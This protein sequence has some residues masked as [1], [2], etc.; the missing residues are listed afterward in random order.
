MLSRRNRGAHHA[1]GFHK[2]QNSS[3]TRYREPS[4]TKT[5]GRL[6]SCRLIP[7]FFAVAVLF[8]LLSFLAGSYLL[9]V[10]D[11]LSTLLESSVSVFTGPQR[12]TDRA[13]VGYRGIYHIE[14]GDIGGAAGTVFFQF[15]IGQILWAEMYNFK[16]WVHLNNVSYIV[17]DP[18]VHGQGPGVQFTMQEGPNITYIHRPDGH[19]KDYVPGPPKH[20]DVLVQKNYNF[21][22]NGVWNNYFEPVS[23]F[24]PGDTSCR[25]KPLVTMDLYQVTPGVHGFA[26]WAPR[27][28]RYEYLPDY[29]TRPHI[30]LQEWLEPQRSIGHRVLNQYIRF[31]P[32]IRRKAENFNPSCSLSSNSCLG[33]HIRQSDK[34]AGRR[35]IQTDEFLPYVLAFVESGG[36]SIYL[37]TDSTAVV[38]H[39]KTK[40]PADIQK[41]IRSMGDDIIR[42]TSTEAVFDIGS[43]H[44][45]NTEIFIEI[46]AL[47]KCQF[48]IHGLSAVTETSIWINL[49][50]HA[51][52]VNLEDPDH[53]DVAA[54]KEMVSKVLSGGNATEIMLKRRTSN[55]WKND[56]TQVWRRQ[57]THAACEGSAGILH[58]AHVG[59]RAGAGTAFFT[60]VVN[61]LIYAEDNNLTPWIHLGEEAEY[62][63]EDGVHGVGEPFSFQAKVDHDISTIRHT[64]NESYEYPGPLISSGR[65]QTNTLS[66]GGTGIWNSYF[67]PVSDFHKDDASCHNQPLLSMEYSMVTSP[68]NSWSPWSVKAW[69][70]D[71]IP[72]RLWKDENVKLKDFLAPMRLR[73]SEIVKKH[74]RF[75]SFIEAKAQ[76][77]NPVDASSPCLAVHLRNSDKGAEK[78]R[79]KFPPNKF[80]AYMQAFINA[81]GKHIFIASDS[82]RTLEYIR[83]HFPSEMNN[84][85]RTQGQYV[86]R[87]TKKWPI[88]SLEK[89]HRTNSEALV[90]ILAMSKCSMLLHGHSA[91][92]EAAIYL[93]PDLHNTSVNWEDPDKMSVQEFEDMS[94]TLLKE[95]ALQLTTETAMVE[96]HIKHPTILHG[97][98]SRTCRK[99]AIVYLA[100][101]KHSSYKGRDSY[102]LLLESLSLIHKNYL[103]LNDHADNVDIIIFH[104]ADFDAADLDVFRSRFG[105]GFREMVHFV[106]LAN[107]TYWKR[108]KWHESDS[109]NDWY[110]FPLFSEGYRRMMHFFAVD[111]WNFFRD[112]EESSG[113]SYRYIMRFD[114]DSYLHSPIQYNIFDF[115]EKNKY[116]YGF[117]LCA[118]E[119]QV[120]QR[121]W[122]LWRRRKNN[123]KPI[124]DIEL[125]MCGIYNNFFVANLA[126][127]QS[128]PVQKF[129]NFV[130]RQGFI[131]RRRLG[132]LMIHSM[133][134]YAFTPPEQIHRFLDFTYEHG[135]VNHTSGCVV[136]GG[137]QAGYDDPHADETLNSFWQRKVADVGNC[138][139]KD[140]LLSKENL[141]PTY[142]HLPPE[143]AG[144]QL[145]TIMD[146]KI[147]LPDKGALS[148]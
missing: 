42:S 59:H 134:T 75:H 109:P 17:Y 111:I 70:Y 94:R 28:W 122:R 145:R 19:M 21:S 77:V 89:H 48:M 97:S 147:E 99:N 16:P 34:A 104:T 118:Y 137:I 62:I 43:H 142:S 108:P 51:T 74:F 10:E 85:I 27:C 44:R 146:G 47:S 38:D 31:L 129:L 114:E 102:G 119:M 78:H 126:H 117:R 106:D 128:Q 49:D 46:L 139:N 87:S 61:Q 36:S 69:R 82:H 76:E 101:K 32:H 136:W 138:A 57:P 92:S 4:P 91:V 68:L 26:E 11:S 41:R 71:D 55:W 115:M 58:I 107:T 88:H 40:W 15:V 98:E 56:D 30:P 148:G 64:F 144:V 12:P 35:Q 84:A 39:I 105:E 18:K 141:S 9:S 22:G 2:Q 5:R 20:M 3:S 81:G 45:T 6:T 116:L 127:F 143:K 63:Y 13:C 83:E 8:M 100:Q 53:S 135:T 95:S 133:A 65:A 124:R 29:I 93:N 14:K 120:T 131:Y 33:I 132:D 96:G 54:F 130:D 66:F 60:S 52:S 121:I 86:V 72:D 103:T 67:E 7:C 125:E 24:L 80:R 140:F 50:L 25:N 113:C 112:Y 1:R 23:D 37:A 90:D 110:A 73:A 123:P 79:G